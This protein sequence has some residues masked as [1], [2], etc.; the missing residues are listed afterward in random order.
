MTNL[1]NTDI[2]AQP[3][4]RRARICVSAFDCAVL[5]ALGSDVGSMAGLLACHVVAQDIEAGY[6]ECQVAWA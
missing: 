5:G 6:V 2:H 1:L 4:L 3:V